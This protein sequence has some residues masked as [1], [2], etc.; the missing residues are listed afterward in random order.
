MTIDISGKDVEEFLNER[1]L[2]KRLHLSTAAHKPTHVRPTTI[3]T[4]SRSLIALL[5]YSALTHAL[6]VCLFSVPFV[7]YNFG[8][9]DWS[10]EEIEG[11]EDSDSEFDD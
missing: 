7:Q 5:M 11:K 6:V 2:G 9:R 1:Y 4:H 10:F 8:D 3:S